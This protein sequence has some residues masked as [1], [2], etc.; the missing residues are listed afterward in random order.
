MKTAADQLDRMDALVQ[1]LAASTVCAQ[2]GSTLVD[3]AKALLA[4]REKPDD[5]DLAA[6]RI[7]NASPYDLTGLPVERG[8]WINAHIKD[9]VLAGIKHG[10]EAAKGNRDEQFVTVH[11]TI[12]HF[13]LAENIQMSVTAE[14]RMTRDILAA[15]GK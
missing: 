10:R 15:L 11:T 9:A 3:D 14:S 5:D 7:C 1:K 12:R 4:E 13:V 2:A 6:W 8:V